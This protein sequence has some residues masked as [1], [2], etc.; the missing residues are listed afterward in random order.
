MT[1]I[2]CTL[3]ASGAPVAK[4]CAAFSLEPAPGFGLGGAGR[5][6]DNDFEPRKF[7]LDLGARQ[8]VQP[9]HQHRGL[10]HRGLRAIEAL[11]R[12]VRGLM[13][14]AA[15]EAGP[16][17]MFAHLDDHKLEMRERRRQT[18]RGDDRS[19]RKRPVATAR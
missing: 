17:L 18:R 4:T 15:D 1:G 12:R 2:A 8:H 10:D 14:D 5:L 13:R 11:E 7:R 9:A 16:E 19:G 6:A 3:Q